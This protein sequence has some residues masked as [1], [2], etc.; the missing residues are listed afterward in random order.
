MRIGLQAWGSE[1]DIQ[2][3]AALAAGLVKS[4]HSVTLVVTDNAGR[5]YSELARRSGYHLVPVPNPVIP[6]RDEAERVWRQIIKSVTR[7]D[8]RSM[9]CGLGS[10]PQPRRCTGPLVTCARRVTPSSVIF[11]STHCG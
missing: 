7:S 4:G 1:G 2:P 3:F 11:S 6:H 5:D 9:S 8:R 10:T